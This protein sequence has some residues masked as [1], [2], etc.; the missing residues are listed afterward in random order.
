MKKFDLN[1]I[2]QRRKLLGLSCESMAE[3]MGLCD[4]S[5]YYKYESGSTRFRAEMLPRLSYILQCD[6][7]NF[8]T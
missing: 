5:A 6:I 8:F 4:R 7:Q 3:L 1:Y 2:K